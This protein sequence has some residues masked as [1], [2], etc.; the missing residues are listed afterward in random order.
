VFPSIPDAV[1]HAFLGPFAPGNRFS[2]AYTLADW[3]RTSARVV[4]WVSMSCMLIRRAPLDEVG[5]LDES[6][7][8]YGE[9]LDLCARFE[10]A[11]WQVLFTPEVEVVHAVGVSTAQADVRWKLREHSRGVYRYFA[12][13]RARGWRRMLLPVA[14]VTL[15]VRAA[16]VA[17]RLGAS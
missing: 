3:D 16:V 11:G 14:W 5:E 6:F 15:R 2:R 12:K 17:R 7:F 13:H 1:G 10:K 9:E 8:L 4:D